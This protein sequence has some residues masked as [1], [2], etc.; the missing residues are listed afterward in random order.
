MKRTILSLVLL[1]VTYMASNAQDYVP[2]FKAQHQFDTQYGQVESKY[3]FENYKG[4]HK[5]WQ[6]NFHKELSDLL[7]VT[8][9]QERY[10]E[11]VP[12]A[13]QL[14]SEDLGFATRERWQIWTEP[15]MIIPMVIIRPKGDQKNLTLC[16]TPQ[17][18]NKNPEVYSG[19]AANEKEA[20]SFEERD[21]DVAY[22]AAKMGF[23][24]INPTTRAFGKT[25]HPEDLARKKPRNSSCNYYAMRDIIA[26]RVL[27]GDR[28]WD[29]MKIIDWALANLPIDPNKIVVTGNSGGGT[30]TLYAGA[31]DKRISLCA[32]SS[33]FC[34]F[35]GSIGSIYH[36]ACNYIP[37]ILKLCNMGDIAG[38]VAPRKLLIINGKEDDIF[39]IGPA[40]EEFKSAQAV[41][42]AFGA[43]QNCELFEGHAGHRYYF[44]GFAD[45]YNR[46][47]K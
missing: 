5:K 36:C 1:A 44:A 43:E 42:K 35:E 41:Y 34:S 2:S 24:T 19:I 47:F 3:A 40:R 31:I 8:A 10:K 20:K 45:Y 46:H 6:K 18:H 26:G 9:L 15:T 7:G 38:L 13:E 27:I 14:D 22:R 16:I 28:V 21:T 11:F 12:K 29:I 4:S 25:M 30:A 37:G 32:P 17:G 39:P 33:A 23:I